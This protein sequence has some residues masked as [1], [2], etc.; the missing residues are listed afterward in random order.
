MK[1]IYE[2]W[3]VREEMRDKLLKMLESGTDEFEL[4]YSIVDFLKV[5]QD[6]GISKCETEYEKRLIVDEA[7]YV[8][9]DFIR[10][11]V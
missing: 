1:T 9:N 7:C 4:E 5:I 11:K 10:R 8:L 6:L 3:K 2:L